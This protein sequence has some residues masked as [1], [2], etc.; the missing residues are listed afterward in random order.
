MAN[1]ITYHRPDGQEAVG[2]Y[3]E[4]EAGANAPAI[5]VI[6]EWWGLN[7]QIKGVAQ[8][9]AAEGYRVLVPDLYRGKVTVETAEAQHLM[10]HLD[11]GDAATQDIRGAVQHLKASGP[12]VAVMGYC[13]GGAL[14]VLAAIHSPELDAAVCWYG[15]PPAEAGDVR[16]IRSPFQGHFAE[17]DEHFPMDQVNSLEQRLQ[18]GN[19]T[20]EFYRYPAK[21]AFANETGPNYNPDAKQQ[22]WQR[23]LNFL[24]QHLV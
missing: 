10:S 7:N 3:V 13:M 21:H 11:F 12:K 8:A 20:Y 2:Y 24:A 1:N 22:A 14:T 9:L 6:Q 17:Q 4:P 16:T 23:S 18:E 15:V 5:V 19:V